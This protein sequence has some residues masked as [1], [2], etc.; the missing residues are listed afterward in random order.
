MDS[1]LLSTQPLILALESAEPI[2]QIQNHA[3]PCQVHPCIAPQSHDHLQSRDS[4]RIKEQ[5]RTGSFNRFEETICH[6]P[7]DQAGMDLGGGGEPLQ[8]QLVALPSAKHDLVSSLPHRLLPV[9]RSRGLNRDSAA[10]FPNISF[11]LA[12][13]FGGITIFSWRY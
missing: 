1:S 3:D 5:H 10:S 11:S 6:E 12:D 8:C 7:F 9:M 13:S 2:Q 4:G